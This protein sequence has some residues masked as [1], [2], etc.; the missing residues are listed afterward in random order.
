[1][2]DERISLPA[3]GPRAVEEWMKRTEDWSHAL[4][5][6]AGLPLHR[7]VL[8][9][10]V[11]AFAG[12]YLEATLDVKTESS[13]VRF[14]LDEIVIEPTGTPPSALSTAFDAPL[15][16]LARDLWSIV[17]G[18]K[19]VNRAVDRQVRDLTERVERLRDPGRVRLDVHD[20]ELEAGALDRVRC[21]I[22]DLRLEPGRT[23]ML[24]SGPI[25]LAVQV[26]P[27]TVARWVERSQ[28]G[29]RVVA[30]GDRME[31]TPADRRWTFVVEPTVVGA[32]LRARVV[33]VRRGRVDLGLPQRFV[34]TYS[35]PIPAPAPLVVEGAALDD[36]HLTVAYR[37]PGIRQPVSPDRVRELV[38][39]GSRRFTLADLARR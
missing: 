39:Q 25:D 8:L 38:A 22:R 24:V 35:I 13:T 26:A 15:V 37:H 16:D 1:M 6:A 11:E 29:T 19:R 33:R 5:T 10:M 34:R 3:W 17:P 18:A 9:Q 32:E 31:I 12:Q 20:V 14:T 21:E 4:S 7:R 36:D 23:A 27:A 28:P 2:S 30:V